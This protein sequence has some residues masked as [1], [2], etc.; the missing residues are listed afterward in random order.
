MLTATHQKIANYN[1][2]DS[3]LKHTELRAQ[4]I[5]MAQDIILIVVW[6]INLHRIL[7]IYCLVHNKVFL[8]KR[9][10]GKWGKAYETAHYLKIWQNEKVLAQFL[11]KT[12]EYHFRVVGDTGRPGCTMF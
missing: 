7:N 12:E 9:V 10:G 1:L 4:T 3:D 2:K 8:Q 11:W 5:K 6:I